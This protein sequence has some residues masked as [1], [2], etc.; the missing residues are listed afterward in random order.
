MTRPLA[1]GDTPATPIFSPQ[2]VTSRSPSLKSWQ[3][4]DPLDDD[5]IEMEKL[6]PDKLQEPPVDIEIP[7]DEGD[8][9]LSSSDEPSE[10]DQAEELEETARLV[11]GPDAQPHEHPEEPKCFL[12]KR[13]KVVHR[14]SQKSFRR[15]V[16]GVKVTENYE[17]ISGEM[18]EGYSP[19]LSSSAGAVAELIFGLTGWIYAKEGAKHVCFSHVIS[20]LGVQIDLTHSKD[21]DVSS[22]TPKNE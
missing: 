2:E 18:I 16:C 11:A 5:G 14:L 7:S 17:G 3:P 22:P 15:F 1:Q 8:G 19:S 21:R 4:P 12:N 20:A 13:N 10:D 9:D 6:L